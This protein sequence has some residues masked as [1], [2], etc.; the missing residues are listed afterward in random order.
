MSS[1]P[2]AVEPHSARCAY[3]SEKARLSVIRRY[4][5]TDDDDKLLRQLLDPVEIDSCCRFI[6]RVIA[7]EGL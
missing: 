7:F 4:Y 3:L 2:W 6:D 5:R 1:C